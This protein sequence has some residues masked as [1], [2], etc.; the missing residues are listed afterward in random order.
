MNWTKKQIQQYGIFCVILGFLLGVT[1]TISILE[2][3][4]II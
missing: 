1:G 4:G 3:C 2:L